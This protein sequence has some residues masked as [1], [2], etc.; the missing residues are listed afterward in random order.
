MPPPIHG[1]NEN[2]LANHFSA[3]QQTRREHEHAPQ[4]VHDR[5]NRGEQI[6]EDRE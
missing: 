4:S 3:G 2:V 1:M 6:D 5:R